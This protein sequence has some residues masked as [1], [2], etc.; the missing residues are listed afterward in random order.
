MSCNPIIIVPNKSSIAVVGGDKQ[1]IV[2]KSDSN[3]TVSNGSKGIAV[4]VD[5]PGITVDSNVSKQITVSKGTIITINTGNVTALISPF[6]CAED[7]SAYQVVAAFAS[8]IRPA[9]VTNVLH[10]ENV[11]GIALSD[12]LA[13]D[14]VDVATAGRVVFA[15]WSW[16]DT[17]HLY[18]SDIPG[19]MVQDDIDQVDGAT[20]SL[21][22]GIVRDATSIDLNPQMPILY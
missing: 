10:A 22:M 11:V 16:D 19:E 18:L 14:S 3:I 4:D 2:S 12:C 5:C 8:S 6:V 17:K 9:T 20:F 15:G 13:G 7:I 1:I 21:Q